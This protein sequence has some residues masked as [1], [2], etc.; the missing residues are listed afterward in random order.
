M[1]MLTVNRRRSIAVVLT[2]MTCSA[3]GVAA[4]RLTPESVA[5]WR[6]YVS[7]TERR[8]A[9]EL[10]ARDRFLGL[11][12]RSDAAAARQALLGGQLVVQPLATTDAR[13]GPIDVP[14][15]LLQHWR[16]AVF[17]PG[18]TVKEML[19]R[20][21]SEAPPP[22]QDDVVKSAVLARGPG[23]MSV[24]LQLRA[25]KVVTAFYN[26]EH[27]VRFANYGAGRAT[28]TSTAT[29]IAELRD[30]DTPAERELPQG[31][32]RGFLWRLNAYWRYEDVPGGVIA[33]SE[34]VT[35]SRSV[36][37]VVGYFVRPMIE[38]TARESMERAV[39][40]LRARFAR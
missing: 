17:I 19:A 21:E 5:A 25:K 18:T 31:D 35:L 7:A 11:D 24:Y 39:L 27:D 8:I 37:S 28:S 22:G 23:R 40:S 1:S 29:K 4:A 32:D 30:F 34:S 26:T 33:E 3:A 2:M 9:L 12:F 15:A 16:G 13:G 36:P 6:T 20:L 10:R 14:A 38:S